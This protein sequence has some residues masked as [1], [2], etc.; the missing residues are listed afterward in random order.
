VVDGRVPVGGGLRVKGV[1]DR[2]AMGHGA[3]VVLLLELSLELGR[4]GLLQGVDD[5][6]VFELQRW[7]EA[8]DRM[9][10]RSVGH[11]GPVV[12]PLLLRL[13]HG[14]ETVQLAY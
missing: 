6:Q 10:K 2:L 4:E 3:L 13:R 7:E 1:G 8:A 11:R 9:G 5:R 12:L 14:D